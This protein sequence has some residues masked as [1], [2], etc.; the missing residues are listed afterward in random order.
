MLVFSHEKRNIDILRPHRSSPFF[1]DI[2]L[3]LKEKRSSYWNN[4]SAFISIGCTIV[5][6]ISESRNCTTVRF[7][8]LRFVQRKYIGFILTLPSH[9]SN[10][11]RAPSSLTLTVIC[12]VFR[13]FGLASKPPGLLIAEALPTHKSIGLRLSVNF[14]EVLLF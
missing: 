9:L 14:P 8:R 3:I 1:V 6:S 11:L 5:E 7:T 12:R 10:H 13:Q 4:F 2:T